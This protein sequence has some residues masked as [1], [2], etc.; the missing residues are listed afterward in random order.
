ME[1]VIRY[2]ANI[3]TA[4]RRPTKKAD[5]PLN[6]KTLTLEVADKLEALRMAYLLTAGVEPTK[7]K[8]DS[9]INKTDPQ[10]AQYIEDDLISI[11]DDADLGAG[12]PV[13]LN[14]KLDGEEIY[15]AGFDV[16]VFLDES[17]KVT[18]NF[19]DEL[20]EEENVD[21]SL[22]DNIEKDK[23]YPFGDKAWMLNE[24]LRYMNDE[25][26]YYTSGWL[27]VWPDECS[28]EECNSYFGETQEDY[29]EL[30]D[31]FKRI[32]SKGFYHNSGLYNAPKEV[33]DAAHEWDKKLGLSPIKVID[34]INTEDEF[35]GRPMDDSEPQLATDDREAGQ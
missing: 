18:E 1:A 19:F 21:E 15:D 33:I 26:A 31:L 28:R 10:V 25:G 6:D 32:Y 4:E 11:L 8:W 34:K 2:W 17:P 29:E 13:V 20:A 27:Y 35:D 12:Q 14:I 24:I 3:P 5:I 9:Y 16:D 22:F 30:E 7:E 23:K